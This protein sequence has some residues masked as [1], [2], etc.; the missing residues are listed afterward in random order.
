MESAL[1]VKKADFVF[2]QDEPDAGANNPQRHEV[3][4]SFCFG[5]DFQNL[6]GLL[7]K[8]FHGGQNVAILQRLGLAQQAFCAVLIDIESENLPA[9]LA[10][11]QKFA[12]AGKGIGFRL[13]SLSE[14]SDS[15]EQ[16]QN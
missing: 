9:E 16:C 8:R 7:I 6:A 10:V 2:V 11:N 14:Y 4:L 13:L 1:D 3:I 15:G 12:G 5:Q